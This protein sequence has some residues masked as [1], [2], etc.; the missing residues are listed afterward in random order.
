MPKSR[1]AR[2]RTKRTCAVH[3]SPRRGSRDPQAPGGC[4]PTSPTLQPDPRL[5]LP[6]PSWLR[7]LCLNQKGSERD[8]LSMA[9]G[10]GTCVLRGQRRGRVWGQSVPGRRAGGRSGGSVCV[11]GRTP[12]CFPAQTCNRHVSSRKQDKREKSR[13][14]IGKTPV[15]R[16][17][18]CLLGRGDRWSTAD[19]G[20]GS[21]RPG[22]RGVSQGVCPPPWPPPARWQDVQS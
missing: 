8:D 17:L 22:R 6:Q 18:V 3:R 2:C 21:G 15:Q 20:A 14:K 1:Q 7:H 12:R 5:R 10:G 11:Y 13:N 19:A 9:K 16:L 4:S